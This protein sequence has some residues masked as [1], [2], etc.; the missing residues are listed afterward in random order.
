VV[1]GEGQRIRR[2]VKGFGRRAW[3]KMEKNKVL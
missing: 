1:K 3:R 2:R